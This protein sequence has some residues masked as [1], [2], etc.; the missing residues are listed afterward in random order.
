MTV[1][2]AR[3]SLEREIADHVAAGVGQAQLRGSPFPHWSIGGLLPDDVAQT[4]AALPLAPHDLRGLSGRRELHNDERQYFAGEVLD[5]HPTALAVA[6]A[7]QASSVVA[8]LAALTGAVLAGAYLRVEYALD[9]DGFWLEPHTDL[10][11]K[12]LTLF[13]QFAGPGQ[14]SLGT[15]LYWGPGAWALRTPFAWNAALVFIPS[16]RSW[17]GFEPRPIAGV[18]RSLIVNY[19]TDAWRAREQLAFPDRPVTGGMT[20]L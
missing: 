4:V 3:H 14:E 16:D 11:V 20:K 6:Q 1:G 18:R 2:L 12:L 8:A 7:F 17:H 10:G 19:V 9:V 13:L 5:A 15:D